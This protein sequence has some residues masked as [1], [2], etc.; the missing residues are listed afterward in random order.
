VCTKSATH[1]RRERLRGTDHGSA[2]L[3]IWTG[4]GSLE[5]ACSELGNSAR[6]GINRF[7]PCRFDFRA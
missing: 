2:L 1:V 5:R 3:S 6:H 4:T 7:R